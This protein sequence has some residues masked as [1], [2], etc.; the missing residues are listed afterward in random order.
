MQLSATIRRNPFSRLL[1]VFL[2]GILTSAFSNRMIILPVLIFLLLAFFI[3]YIFTCRKPGFHTGLYSG[4][5]AACLLFFAGMT[6]MSIHERSSPG[7]ENSNIRGTVILEVREPLVTTTRSVRTTGRIQLTASKGIFKKSHQKLLLY[8]EKDSLSA[9]LVPGNRLVADI[10]SHKITPPANPGEFDYSRYLA[11]SGIFIQAYV[12]SE[13]WRL[14]STPRIHSFRSV[15]FDL[16]QILLLQYRKTG[17][18]QTLYSILSALTLGY[19]NDL[20]AHT[21]KVFSE[22]GVMHVMALSGFNVA[23]IALALGYLLFFTG[24]FRGG[25]ILKTIV[26]LLMIWLFVLVTGLSPSVTRAAVMISFILTGALVQRKT[27]T[28]NILFITAFILLAWVPSLI[29]D[30]SFQLSF[31]AVAGILVLHPPLYKLLKFRFYL[32][33]KVWQLFTVS[34]AAQMATLPLTLFYFHQFPVYFWLTNLYV[35][36]LVSVIICVAG[37]FLMV[38]FCKPLMLLVGKALALLVAFLYKSVAFTEL[39]PFAVIENIRINPLQTIMLIMVL[40]LISLGLVLRCKAWLIPATAALA[41]VVFAG[42]SHMRSVNHQRMILVG[43]YRN[44]SAIHIITGRKCL[45]LTNPI[46]SRDEPRLHYAFE[47]FWIEQGIARHLEI[48]GFDAPAGYHAPWLGKNKLVT[49]D[50]KRV[51]ILADNSLFKWKSLNPLIV[52]VLIITGGVDINISA[53]NE[54]VKPRQIIL[55]S[56]VN[57][58]EAVYWKNAAKKEGIPCNNVSEEEAF[59]IAAK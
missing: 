11:S 17:M 40:L 26:I 37:L 22:A 10:S 50:E 57:P 31:A 33:D 28:G 19:K 21:R 47:N 6:V 13:S 56:S 25:N 16:Q 55:D 43:N 20:D 12:S 14:C 9:K 51:L 5:L 3:S 27:K 29:R 48:K 58:H 39:L 4:L 42:F 54:I 30:V 38:S 44:A 35:I 1:L 46:S 2:A 41:V 24:K 32:A 45:L 49:L 59:L 7:S 36:P 34:C 18:E 8:F 15:A 23:V 53:L 52:D